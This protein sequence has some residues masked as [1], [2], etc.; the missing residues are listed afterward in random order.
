MK[1]INTILIANRGE[2][3]SRIIRTC[4][5]IGI[6]CVAVYSEADKNAPFV[7]Q[8]DLAIHIGDPEPSK[9][10]LDQ[11]KIIAAALR[12][13]ADAIHPGYGFLSENASFAQRCFDEG[14]IFIGPK[15]EVIE[16]MGSKSHA[17]MI[18]E[19]S[20][21]PV[22]PGYKGKAQSDAILRE[23]ALKVGFPLL[24]KAT[25][26]GGGKGMRIVYEEKDLENAIASAKR[27]AKNAFG[28]D[29]LLIEKYIESGRH[30]EFQIFGDQHGNIIHLLERECTIQRRYQ[31]VIEESPSPVMTD[32]LRTSMGEAA[33]LAAKSLNYDNAGTVEFIFDDKTQN[34]YFLEV[35][36]RLQVEHP[37]TE[38]ITG[39]DLV[40][41]QIESAK[42]LPLLIR[43]DEVKAN[44]YAIEARLYAED[45]ANN[46]APV[47]GTIHTFEFSNIEGLRIESAIESGSEIS[48]FYD[49][50][51]AKIIVS[52]TDRESAHNKL[53]YALKHLVCQ[54]TITNQSFLQTLLQHEDFRAGKYDTHFID[55]RIDL[56]KLNNLTKNHIEEIALA[57]TLYSWNERE[58][59]RKTLRSLPSGWRNN[60]Y[61]YHKEIFLIN[62]QEVIVQYRFLDNNFTV[63][64]DEKET[65]ANIID[66]DQNLIRLNIS[67]L[68]KSFSILKVNN[69]YY[70]HAAD[71]GN[72]SVIKKDR[73][74][75]KEKEKVNGGYESPIPSQIVKIHI[76]TGEQI[77]KGD[78]LLVLS[79][80][81]METVI[82]ADEDGIIEEVYVE[83]GNN[84]EA[85]FLLLKINKN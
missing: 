53:S 70:V 56:S 22:I 41:M 50:M 57:A 9:S 83:E 66:V 26:G 85:G 13:G 1:N 18:M 10:Y 42:G 58:V 8:A 47:T 55:K 44:G 82:E 74:P 5:K 28:D 35:N 4:K 3:A 27:E 37:V 16:S 29:E 20:G 49:P 25:A 73:F 69:D 24:L 30:I 63:I 62:D 6:T 64:I 51:I 33:V 76:A 68:Q 11:D 21:V 2:I 31:K 34:F 45:A 78:P 59:S 54:G 36:T 79:S 81:K 61:E 60:F 77:T 72:V 39:L 19:Q 15:P 14:I 32:A 75:A 23:E 80:M 43:Q 67:G 48:M 40:Q 65:E 38:A 46:F 71:I 84:V 12:S 52:D 7:K 17:K